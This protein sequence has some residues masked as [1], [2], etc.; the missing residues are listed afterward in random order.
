MSSVISTIN[1][2]LVEQAWDLQVKIEH[3]LKQG[4]NRFGPQEKHISPRYKERLQ[5]IRERAHFRYKR[6][7]QKLWLQMG[8]QANSLSYCPP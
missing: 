1:K 5:Q 6:R 4:Y 3:S 2:S 8:C 7:L